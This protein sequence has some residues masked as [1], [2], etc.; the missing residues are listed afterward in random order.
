MHRILLNRN[1]MLFNVSLDAG[2][3][4]NFRPQLAGLIG[5]LP[6]APTATAA[7]AWQSEPKSEGL[8]VPAQVNYVVQGANLYK[9]GYQL[10]GSSR[11]IL[12]FMSTTYMWEKIRVL[13]GAYGGFA[14]FDA[15]SGNFS[16]MSY[17]DP[18]L[19][20]TLT[21]YA[22]AGD[23]LQNVELSEEEIT[24][25]IIGAIGAMDAHLLPD[26]KGYTSMMYYLL[27][28]TDE[29]RQ[30]IRDQVLST[31]ADDF[32]Q[33]GA[34]LNQIQEN[35]VVVVVGSKDNISAANA[36]RGDFLTVT[37]VL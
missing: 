29:E 36:E 24:R 23:F 14:S 1:A 21:N 4:A 6:A 22:G 34:V 33:F 12:Q 28:Y 5:A 8:T 19:V 35:G 16:F 9:L 2:N 30:R 37:N 10:D 20:G 11:V 27:R 15:F 31:T 7:W 25:S 32:R 18:N 26:A 17:R 3:W 13:G